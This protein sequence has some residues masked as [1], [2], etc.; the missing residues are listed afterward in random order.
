MSEWP[1]RIVGRKDLM[2]ASG[3]P[4]DWFRYGHREQAYLEAWNEFA[5]ARSRRHD[6]MADF[7]WNQ[8]LV[9]GVD[10][11]HM[12]STIHE[13]VQHIDAVRSGQVLQHVAHD[14][15]VE[16]QSLSVCKQVNHIHHP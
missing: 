10:D 4:R 8:I 9:L 6:F 7:S 12:P 1:G 3:N 13:V 5:D 15:Q 2:M 16:A 14:N 11:D